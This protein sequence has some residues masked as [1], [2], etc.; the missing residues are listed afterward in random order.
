[1]KYNLAAMHTA[2]LSRIYANADGI[3]TLRIGCSTYFWVWK[4][5]RIYQASTSNSMAGQEVYN[6]KQLPFFY[7]SILMPLQ[8]NVCV[9]ITVNYRELVYACN[10]ILF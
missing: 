8:K 6:R 9:L 2:P 4:K 7:P 1:M 5:T 3:G 10:G